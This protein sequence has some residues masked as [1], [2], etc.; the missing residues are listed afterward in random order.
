MI[1]LAFKKATIDGLL[2]YK[3]TQNEKINDSNFQWSLLNAI[4]LTRFYSLESTSAFFS[5]R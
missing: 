4:M 1:F 2:I 5:F 3:N